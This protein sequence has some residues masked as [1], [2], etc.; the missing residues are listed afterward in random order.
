[1]CSTYCVSFTREVRQTAR[2]KGCARFTR[3]VGHPLLDT[4]RS[5]PCSL[6]D[7]ASEPI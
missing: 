4:L 6:A 2:N 1:M 5:Q 3:N 7:I